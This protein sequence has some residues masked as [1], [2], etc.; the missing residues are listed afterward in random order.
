MAE[1]LRVLSG[2]KNKF[3]HYEDYERC[4][5]ELNRSILEINRINKLS[6]GQDPI[7]KTYHEQVDKPTENLTQTVAYIRK[8]LGSVVE[9]GNETV[10]TMNNANEESG[11]V[12]ETF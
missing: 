1:E 12:V 2:L 9:G 10:N 8:R 4:L 5:A 11:Q 3:A 6:G 7:G